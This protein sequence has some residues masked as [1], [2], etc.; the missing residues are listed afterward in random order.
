MSIPLENARAIERECTRVIHELFYALDE[1][2]YDALAYAFCPDGVWRRKGDALQG[3][4]RILQAM[5][6]RSATVRVRH[7]ITNVL[8]TVRTAEGADFVLYLTAYMHDDGTL[9]P[10][11]VVISSPAM[12]LVVT[13]SLAYS[14]HGWKIREMN[15]RREFEFAQQK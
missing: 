8:V 7:V 13:G 1:R 5:N 4:Q 11:P 12:L 6:E 14:P 9:D 2:R 3:R 10:R 15:M